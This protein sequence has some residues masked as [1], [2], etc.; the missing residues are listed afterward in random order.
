MD[1]SDPKGSVADAAHNTNVPKI[2]VLDKPSMSLE[3]VLLSS[4]KNIDGLKRGQ[5]GSLPCTIF[6]KSVANESEKNK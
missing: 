2:L 5:V 1:N 3:M 4:V 6:D